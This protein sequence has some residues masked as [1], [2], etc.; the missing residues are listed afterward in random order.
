[1]YREIE[2]ARFLDV[3]TDRFHPALLDDFLFI[4]DV[5]FDLRAP[6]LLIILGEY[7]KYPTDFDSTESPHLQ[8]MED[9]ED[10]LDEEEMKIES[11]SMMDLELEPHD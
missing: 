6:P 7:H 9:D 10:F 4:I 11:N 8:I 5:I 1:M 2:H 3:Y